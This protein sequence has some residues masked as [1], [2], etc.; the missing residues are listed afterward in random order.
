[1]GGVGAF[2]AS[3]SHKATDGDDRATV[4]IAADP[5]FDAWQRREFARGV[6]YFEADG[7]VERVIDDLIEAGL[8]ESGWI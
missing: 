8:K 3:I 2:P 5:F 4:A 6:E 7:D 1:M